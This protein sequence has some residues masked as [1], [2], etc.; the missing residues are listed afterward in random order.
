MKSYFSRWNFVLVGCRNVLHLGC[1]DETDVSPEEQ[2]IGV[3]IDANAVD[4]LRSELGLNGMGSEQG[5][6]CLAPAR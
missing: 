5:P 2:V 4:L 3:D 1:V 6:C